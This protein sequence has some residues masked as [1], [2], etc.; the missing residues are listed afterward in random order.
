MGMSIEEGAMAEDT[1]D[2]ASELAERMLSKLAE[3]L[4]A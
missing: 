3:T 2:E 1:S 4:A